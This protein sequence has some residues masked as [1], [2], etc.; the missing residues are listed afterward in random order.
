MGE[1]TRGEG[2]VY[3]QLT[4]AER[5]ILYYLFYV[6]ECFCLYVCL[7]TMHIWCR[8]RAWDPLGLELQMAVW[9][10]ELNPGPLEEVLLTSEPSPNP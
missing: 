5:R 6:N 8:E 7:C 3:R 4:A 2:Q 1:S 9:V 10:W